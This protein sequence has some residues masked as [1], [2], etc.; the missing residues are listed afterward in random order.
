MKNKMR[1]GKASDLIV[2][3]DLPDRKE[4]YVG[5]HEWFIIP[6]GLPNEE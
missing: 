5:F 6:N 2:A 3:G 1:K 4:K